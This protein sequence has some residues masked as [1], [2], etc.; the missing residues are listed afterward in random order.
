MK[1]ALVPVKVT[2]ASA[3]SVGPA[4]APYEDSALRT[5]I[6]NAAHG[7]LEPGAT[8]GGLPLKQG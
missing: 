6:S 8:T 4:P 1:P 7:L 5:V 3:L 2:V